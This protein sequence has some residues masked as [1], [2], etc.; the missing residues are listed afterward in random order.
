MIRFYTLCAIG[1]AVL[2]GTPVMAADCSQ[3][4]DVN[5]LKQLLA[6][7]PATGGEEGGLFHGKQEWAA[8]VNRDG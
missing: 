1:A 4:P 5:Q 6:K 3:V 8:T 2:A 7:A